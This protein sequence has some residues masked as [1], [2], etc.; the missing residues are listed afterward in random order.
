MLAKIIISKVEGQSWWQ[1]SLENE[2]GGGTAG[3]YFNTPEDAI[4]AAT[5]DLKNWRRIGEVP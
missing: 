2:L 4:T 3:G 5:E 1:F